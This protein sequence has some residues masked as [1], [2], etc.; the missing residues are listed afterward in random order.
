MTKAFCFASAAIFAMALA[1]QAS[2]AIFV[3]DPNAG[4]DGTKLFLTSASDATSSTGSVASANDVGISVV[5]ASDFA[6]GYANIK[7]SKNGTLTEL[8]FTPVDATLFNSFSFR[9]QSLS[10]NV[11]VDV[12]VTDDQ[13]DAA[14]TLTFNI[15]KANADFG[16]FGIIASGAQTIKSVELLL[17]TGFKEA[18]QFQFDCVVTTMACPNAGQTGGGGGGGGATPE[19][20]TWALLLV[21][22]GG[23]GAS[24]RARRRATLA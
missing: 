21:G 24:L 5:G 6:S 2:A 1:G 17:P 19:P 8:T 18:K 9:G 10:K 7:P 4:S 13:G 12:I 23:M 14:Q 15:S 3:N 16:P 22:L 11:T 20:A